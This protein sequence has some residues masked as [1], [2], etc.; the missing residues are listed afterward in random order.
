MCSKQNREE[1]NVTPLL[2]GL[3]HSNRVTWQLLYYFHYELLVPMSLFL[4]FLFLHCLNSSLS[5]NITKY[6]DI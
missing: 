1:S 6:K 3:H 2:T 4:K 5:N